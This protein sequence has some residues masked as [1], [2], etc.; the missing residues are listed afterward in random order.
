[1]LDRREL[2]RLVTAASFSVRVRAVLVVKRV[3]VAS[4]SVKS[5]RERTVVRIE[6]RSGWLLFTAGWWRGY[7]GGSVTSRETSRWS[8]LGV[9]GGGEKGAGE[10]AV[11]CES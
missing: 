3:L 1:M 11:A 8:G 4:I 10:R 2:R 9:N 5:E 6:V 7:G